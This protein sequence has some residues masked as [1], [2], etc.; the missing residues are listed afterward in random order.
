MHGGFR[1]AVVNVPLPSEKQLQAELNVSW[2][3][4]ARN[5]AH[6]TRHRNVGARVVEIRVVRRVERFKTELSVEPFGN[7]HV[8]QDAEVKQNVARP[9]QQV[10][11]GVAE[12]KGRGNAV[13][14]SI[15]PAVEVAFLPGQVAHTGNISPIGIPAGL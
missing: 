14:G 1:P 9:A 6:A 2:I 4:R 15:E 13:T 3:A 8:F 10:A 11:G 7:L 12:G 5:A